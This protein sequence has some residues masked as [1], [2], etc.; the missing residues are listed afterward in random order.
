MSRI[1]Q[2]QRLERH[3]LFKYWAITIYG[4]PFQA[5]LLNTRFV[6]L[7]IIDIVALQPRLYC[8]KRFGLLRFRSPLLTKY[9][10]VYFP[11]ITEMFHFIGFASLAGSHD[12]THMEFPHSEI[13]GSKVV[14][15]LPETYRSQTTSFIARQNQGIHRTPLTFL[16]GNVKTKCNCLDHSRRLHVHYRCTFYIFHL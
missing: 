12:I 9:L 13:S 2:E 16:L 15:H 14:W 10:L 5:L 4:V 8:Y 7:L 3:V 11:P 6:T 1:T